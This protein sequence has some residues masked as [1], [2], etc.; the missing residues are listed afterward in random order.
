MQQQEPKIV[1]IKEMRYVGMELDH[2]VHETAKGH[3]TIPNLWND[4]MPRMAEVKNPAEKVLGVCGPVR[5]GGMSMYAAAVEVTDTANPPKG[6]VSGVIPAGKYAEFVHHGPIAN[7]HETVS[8]IHNTW[9]PNAGYT[10]HD[11]SQ[12]EVMAKDAD[13]DATDFEMKV[14]VPLF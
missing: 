9:M 4:F 6:M 2:N 3:P 10:D 8:Y 13:V 14:L 7:F 5:K 12:I 11:C 1:Q